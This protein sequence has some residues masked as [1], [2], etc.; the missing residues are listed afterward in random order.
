MG[1]RFSKMLYLMDAWHLSVC[2][3]F[4]GF[5]SFLRLYLCCRVLACS[6]FKTTCPMVPPTPG[7][8][9]SVRREAVGG[10]NHSQRP[11]D[12]SIF[13]PRWVRLVGEFNTL[14][15]HDAG[16]LALLASV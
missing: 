8:P 11:R 6:T 1:I 3:K 10:A 13:D 9:A 7:C 14:G 12:G 5:C 2:I 4:V 15:V 16:T